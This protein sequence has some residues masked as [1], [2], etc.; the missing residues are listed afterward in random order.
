MMAVNV[1]DVPQIS[2]LAANVAANVVTNVS[3][4][5]ANVNLAAANV[6]GIIYF[7]L[8]LMVLKY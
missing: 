5:A 6:I 8:Y 4:A 3:L 7:L 1:T 2:L